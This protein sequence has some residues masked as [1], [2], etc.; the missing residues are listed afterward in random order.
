VTTD[1]RCHLETLAQ[2]AHVDHLHWTQVPLTW[3]KCDHR[4]CRKSAEVL[5]ACAARPVPRE[6]IDG[7]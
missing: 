5:D 6:S 3:D 1:H 4:L 7:D 2:M